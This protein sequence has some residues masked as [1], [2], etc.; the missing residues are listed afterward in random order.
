MRSQQ[1]R[2]SDTHKQG[3]AGEVEMVVR[4]VHGNIIEQPSG[5]NIVK[6]QAKECFAHRLAPARIWDPSGGSGDGA[7][8]AHSIDLEEFSARYIVFGASFNEAGDPLDTTDTRYYIHDMVT[9]SY[10][11]K[12][13]EVGANY[14]GGLINA[15]P[16]AEP[17]RPLKR[18]ERFYFEPSYQ[19]AGTP[20]LQADVRA[21]NNVVVFETTLLREEYNGFGLTGSDFFT[22]TEVA[23]VAAAEVGSVGLCNCNPRDLFL[24]GVDGQPIAAAANGTTTVSIDDMADATLINE[25]DQIKLVASETTAAADSIIDQ[26]NP[27]YLVVAK[28][29]GGRDMVLDRVPVNADGDPITGGVGVFRDGFRVIAHK[30]L[31]APV[32]KSQETIVTCRW[33]LIMG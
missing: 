33:R 32:R 9:G 24:T 1:V 14:D 25:G 10:V 18:I 15:V 23:L 4:D 17:G 21:M 26:T 29:P 2:L 12:T 3:Y 27:Y 5:P 11:A 31:K 16:L 30:I 28:T 22:I 20:L 8:V 19:P 7:W 6:I 13:L